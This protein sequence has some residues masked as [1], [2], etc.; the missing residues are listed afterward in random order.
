MATS[1]LFIA[2]F[3]QCFD[4]IQAIANGMLR[5]LK[6]TFIPMILSVGYH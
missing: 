1:F 5:G 2:A 3:F 6:D 4:A